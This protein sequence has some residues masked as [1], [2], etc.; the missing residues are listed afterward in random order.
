M[1]TFNRRNTEKAYVSFAKIALNR[2]HLMPLINGGVFKIWTCFY[3]LSFFSYVS[4]RMGG[5]VER[6]DLTNFSFE[7]HISE[8][9]TELASNVI[10]IGRIKCG[11]YYHRAL[12]FKVSKL[13]SSSQD[14]LRVYVFLENVLY[15]R[16]AILQLIFLNWLIW[17]LCYSKSLRSWN[18]LDGLSTFKSLSIFPP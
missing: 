5:D 8:L 1:P 14:F 17:P 13:S 3:S 4:D 9:K 12:L 15:F 18:G 2:K 7:L 16:L 10:P 11:I 6:S